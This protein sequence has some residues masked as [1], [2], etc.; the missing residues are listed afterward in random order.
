M[1][2]NPIVMIAYNAVIYVFKF[3]YNGACITDV[4]NWILENAEIVSIKQADK[5]GMDAI[6]DEVNACN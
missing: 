6:R 1:F 4:L 2:V 5:I 3:A